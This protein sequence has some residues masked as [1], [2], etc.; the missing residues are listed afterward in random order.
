MGRHIETIVALAEEGLRL[1]RKPGHEYWV[2]AAYPDDM[3]EARKDEIFDWL[4]RERL[5]VVLYTRWLDEHVRAVDAMLDACEA[6]PAVAD[7]FRR[8]AAGMRD[9]LHPLLRQFVQEL[10]GLVSEA[11]LRRTA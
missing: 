3:P 10:P 4:R 8:L 1:V 6:E 11:R 7:T 5:F 9:A 2:E